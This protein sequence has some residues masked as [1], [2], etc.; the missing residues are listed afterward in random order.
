MFEMEILA[1]CCSRVKNEKVYEMDIPFYGNIVQST[2]HT[3]FSISLQSYCKLKANVPF[4]EIV[5][6]AKCQGCHKLLE[7][8]KKLNLMCGKSAM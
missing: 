4:T 6:A 2:F 1:L 3:A 7:N 8:G 5:N